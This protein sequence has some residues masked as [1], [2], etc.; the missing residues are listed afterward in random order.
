MFRNVYL[1]QGVAFSADSS[2]ILVGNM[3]ERCCAGTAPRSPIGGADPGQR[4]L[5]GAPYR[6]PP[7]AAA[8]TTNAL[9]ARREVRN[10]GK[11]KNMKKEKKK[12]KQK[13]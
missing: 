6:G 12:P 7:I 9:P 1:A 2:V 5:G 11:G 8:T 4:R 3:V 13:K 10:V